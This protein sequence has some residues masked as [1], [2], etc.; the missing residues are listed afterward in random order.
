[1]VALKLIIACLS[2]LITLPYTQLLRAR[3]RARARIRSL[4]VQSP[5]T[6]LFEARP[7]LNSTCS[8]PSPWRKIDQN[9]NHERS[10]SMHPHITMLDDA[11][12]L[13]SLM[14]LSLC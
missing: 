13:W 6:S 9:L 1:M 10:F 2:N 8:G 7:M 11:L 14:A 12:S 4:V 3:A 5:E